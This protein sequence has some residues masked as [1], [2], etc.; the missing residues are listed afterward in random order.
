[1]DYFCCMF[2]MYIFGG[3]FFMDNSCCVFLMYIFDGYI[4]VEL[5]RGSF[6]WIIL[7]RLFLLCISDVHFGGL[8]VLWIILVDLLNGLFLLY[9]SDVHFW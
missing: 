6:W 3:L 2:L 5:F 8:I 7:N 1:M 9:V 4:L